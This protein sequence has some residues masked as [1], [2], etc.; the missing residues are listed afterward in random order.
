MKKFLMTLV[1]A[2]A[3]AANAQDA[4]QTQQKTIKDPNEYNAYM[5]ATSQTDPGQKAAALEAFV[6]QYPNSVVKEEALVGAMSGYQQAG[7][8]AKVAEAA[9]KVLQ[10]YPS[11]IPALAVSVYSKRSAVN[12][13]RVAAAQAPQALAEAA[14]QAQTGLRALQTWN[15]PEGV[16]D[17]DFQKQKIGMG[18]I[19]NGAIAQDA[20][21]RQDWAT[22]Q[23][24]FKE[25][26]AANPNDPLDSYYAGVS[27]LSP[28]P[29]TQENMLTGLWYVARASSLAPQAKQISDFGK[30]YFKKYHGNEQGWDEL[31]NLAK[32]SPTAPADLSTRITPAPTPAEQ[33]AQMIKQNPAIETWSFG[34]WVLLFTYGSPQDKAAAFERIK[35]KP[36]KFQGVVINAAPETV[37]IALTQDA[38]DAKKAEVSVTMAEP[39]KKAPAPGANF[40][41]QANPVSYT[42]E[43]FMITM[44]TGVDLT[45]AAPTKAG[46]AAAKKAPAKRPAKKR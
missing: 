36:F 16:S 19:F 40:S 30:F 42:S 17:A 35:G 45:P 37:D 24:F 6:Q 32:T 26:V 38:I 23:R 33:V 2:F 28:K 39:M 34:E 10:A 21:A 46:K 12:S 20:A 27:F 44:D 14:Q 1:L 11:N 15:K 41:F 18:A 43:P 31:V 29:N 8:A 4:Q 3:A 25:T 7:N 22:A 9:A 13:G 5:S